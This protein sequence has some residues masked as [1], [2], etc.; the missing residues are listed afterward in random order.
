MAIVIKLIQNENQT[1]WGW[2]AKGLKKTNE[3]E[4]KKLEENGT[5]SDEFG[6][7]LKVEPKFLSKIEAVEDAKDTM[8]VE[9]ISRRDIT[10]LPF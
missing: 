1:L 9:G 4:Y 3:V 5:F 8:E 6:D 2:V 10:I 7:T